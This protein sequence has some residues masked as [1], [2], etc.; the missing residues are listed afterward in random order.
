MAFTHSFS[1][2]PG[3]PKGESARLRDYGY[4]LGIIFLEEADP[5]K[6]YMHTSTTLNLSLKR[7]EI[8]NDFI[9]G[10]IYGNQ[11]MYMSN[12][13]NKG[14]EMLTATDISNIAYRWYMD[15]NCRLLGR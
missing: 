13:I 7:K 11:E 9:L 12:F 6:E 3:I 14:E 1:D 10:S 5:L 2:H 4:K 15:N 8:S